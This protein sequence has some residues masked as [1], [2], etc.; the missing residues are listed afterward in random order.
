MSCAPSPPRENQSIDTP[1]T[2]LCLFDEIY[3]NWARNFTFFNLA[4][5][6]NPNSSPS[7]SIHFHVFLPTI[8]CSW[9]VSESMGKVLWSHVQYGITKT[10]FCCTVGYYLPSHDPFQIVAVAMSESELY[11]SII[12]RLQTASCWFYCKPLER[13]LSNF[14]PS[15]SC[16]SYR[17]VTFTNRVQDD[18]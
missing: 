16:I 12:L 3:L 15:M 6:A 4:G 9:G 10:I 2:C 14:L 13:I 7:S 11:E 18:L 5:C 8:I 1:E 17:D